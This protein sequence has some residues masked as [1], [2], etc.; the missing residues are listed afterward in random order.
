MKKGKIEIDTQ[1]TFAQD[2]EDVLTLLY[3]PLITD[4]SFTLYHLLRAMRGKTL[5]MEEM[6]R[7]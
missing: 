4:R 1:G 3:R 5:D 7:L 6:L 2:W